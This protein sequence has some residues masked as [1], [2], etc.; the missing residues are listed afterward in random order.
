MDNIGSRKGFAATGNTQQGL[1]TF[2]ALQALHQLAYRLGLVAGGF[3]VWCKL[4]IQNRY[5]TNNKDKGLRPFI[6]VV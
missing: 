2:A 6:L 4:E 5:I 3:I 1:R